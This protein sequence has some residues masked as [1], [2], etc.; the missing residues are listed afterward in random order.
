MKNPLLLINQ[1]IRSWQT[2]W[3]PREDF[4]YDRATVHFQRLDHQAD[5]TWELQASPGDGEWSLFPEVPG[6][7]RTETGT[8]QWRFPA[9]GSYALLCGDEIRGWIFLDAPD[10]Y[11]RPADAVDAAEFGILPASDT[12]VTQALNDALSQLSARG[13]GTL[14][15]APGLYTTGTIRMQSNTFLHLEAGAV[16]Q[17][18]LDLDEHPLDDPSIAPQNLPRSLVPGTRRRLIYFDHVRNSGITGRGAICGNGSE[19]RKRFRGPRAMM[20]LVRAVG[21]ENL[22]FEGVFLRD[23]EFWNTHLLLCKNVLF[24]GVKVL[25]EIPPPGWESAWRPGSKSVWNNADGINP[26]SSAHIR[27]EDCFFHTG[28]DCVPIKNTG[29]YKNELADVSEI[30]V[31]GCLMRTSTTA[32][33]L[34]TETRGG[35]IRDVIFEDIDVVECSRV[36]GV[37]LKDGVEGRNLRFRNL[38]VRRCNRPFDFWILSREGQTG[39]TLFSKLRN[40]LVENLRIDRMG[41]EGQNQTSHIQG[42]DDTHDVRDITLKGVQIE[43][44]D[45]RELND[46][47]LELNAFARD[48]SVGE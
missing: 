32:M 44:R 33:K 20:Q 16:L 36:I 10:A 35:Q 31:K 2:L 40:V 47:D 26:D 41:T 12:P 43:G 15:F 27:I 6:L 21:C 9:P 8:L 19:M 14:A 30:T 48:V 45:I 22:R 4:S 3:G 46:L 23:S 39:Q 11:A 25:N 17:A 29:C 42:R 13:G 28:D 1:N 7:T 5:D 38:R 18:S 34:G 24:Q 37:D